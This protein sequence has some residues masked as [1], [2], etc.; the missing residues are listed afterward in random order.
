MEK[1]DIKAKEFEGWAKNYKKYLFENIDL[2]STISLDECDKDLQLL[3]KKFISGKVKKEEFRSIFRKLKNSALIQIIK[4]KNIKAEEILK[5][6]ENIG[7][8]KNSDYG[9]DNILK[10]GI[11]GI[12]VR[13][14][15]KIAR[16]TNLNNNN[17]QKVQDEKIEDTL[18]DIINYA[19][20]GEMLTDNVWS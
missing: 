19:T 7:I 11:I 15:D 16:Y 9:S 17:K 8:R 6:A 18:V 10:Y 5:T 4:M 12:I 13:V 14:G 1:K 20:Y 2:N 3:F